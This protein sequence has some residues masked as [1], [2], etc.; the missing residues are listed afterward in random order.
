MI[1]GQLF[2]ELVADAK[3]QAVK[4]SS[5]FGAANRQKLIQSYFE[6]APA[7][8]ASEVWRH[9]YALLLW[10]DRTTG[11]A[12]C[13]ESDKCQPG[14][15]WYGRSLAFHSWLAEQ[16]R[17]EPTEVSEC[18][19]LLFKEATTQLLAAAVQDQS[20]MA[21]RAE[22]QMRPYIGKSFP[23]PGED[24][25]LAQLLESLLEPYLVRSPTPLVWS[26]IVQRLREHISTENK[27]KNLVGEGFE[28][29]LA[30][31]IRNAVAPSLQA[32]VDPRKPINEIPGFGNRVAGDKDNKVDLVVLI[33]NSRRTILITAKWSI[34]AD[35]ERQFA[36]EFSQYVASR[37]DQSPFE[38][39]LVTN[40]FDPARLVRA[41]E[42]VVANAPMF[43]T[44]VHINPNALAAAY[45]APVRSRER[46]AVSDMKADY[47][48]DSE[49]SM[50]RVHRYIESGRLVSL[51]NWIASLNG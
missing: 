37:S 18:I 16:L 1:K 22:R 41:C 35:R 6:K 20:A 11:L 13:Y 19:D 47:I 8:E 45:S 14:K 30:F 46:Y 7:Y 44:V 21:A 15:P 28:D 31:T 43:R 9:V 10:I 33:P 36:S 27:R 4:V 12:H 25:E 3:S 51:S 38:Y 24:P 5:A 40:E 49:T 39:V 48:V 17:I 26:G 50:Q 42:Q 32:V 2:F 29:V 23:V 34:R